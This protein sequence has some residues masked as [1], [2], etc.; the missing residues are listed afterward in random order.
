LAEAVYVEG[1]ATVYATKISR[2]SIC[3]KLPVPIYK[4]SRETLHKHYKIALKDGGLGTPNNLFF[5]HILCQQQ[6]H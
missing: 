5:L 1:V 6:G 3:S 2:G 4:E